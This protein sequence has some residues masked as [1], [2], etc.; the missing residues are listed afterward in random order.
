MSGGS[1]F[2]KSCGGSYRV[3]PGD[4]LSL[5]A[6]RIYKDA[7]HWTAL[8]AWNR[9]VIGDDPD[10]I[11]V[12]TDLRL[13]CIDGLPRTDAISEISPPAT[14]QREPATTEAA[15]VEEVAVAQEAVI[16]DGETPTKPATPATPPPIRLVTGDGQEPFS[17]HSLTGGG[18]LTE[19]MAAALRESADVSG[20][21]TFRIN[22]WGSHFDPLLNDGLMD[23]SFPW[24]RPPCTDLSVHIACEDILFSDPMFEMLMLMFVQV[25]APV[26]FT[27][28]ADMID[29]RVC[30]PAGR[31]VFMLD[32]GDRNW[33]R[34]G[35][36]DLVRAPTVESCF[37]LLAGGGV[38]AVVMNEFT[39]RL[40]VERMG[41]SDQVE[42]LANAPL[43]IVTLHAIASRQNPNA[44]S[45]IAA[46]NRGLRAIRRSG[47]YQQIVDRHLKKVWS[48]L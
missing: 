21:E 26:P 41:L 39:G 44:D 32:E 24:P 47:D 35:T 36:V 14:P 46:V 38:D 3:A 42:G 11:L 16:A 10:T 31:M 12:G 45:A 23:V 7:G 18:M 2:A 8:H 43:G 28:A 5:I 15:V 19:V 27:G 13:S 34:D 37:D 22:D 9:A 4:S 20:F 25:S 1:V 48:G 29:R 6:L 30:R 17:D 40:A 33:V